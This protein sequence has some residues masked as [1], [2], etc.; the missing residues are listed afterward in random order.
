M[1][2]PRNQLGFRPSF[3]TCYQPQLFFKNKCN[4]CEWKVHVL[5]KESPNYEKYKKKYEKE[6]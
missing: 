2:I 3:E 4:E 5:C 6:K 1:E